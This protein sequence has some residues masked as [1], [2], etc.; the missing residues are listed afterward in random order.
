MNDDSTT[1]LPSHAEGAHAMPAA[2]PAEVT[3]RLQPTLAPPGCAAVPAAILHD[4]GNTRR[5]K[6][7]L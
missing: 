7:G 1:W 3:Q 6:V 5:G 2:W 4:A